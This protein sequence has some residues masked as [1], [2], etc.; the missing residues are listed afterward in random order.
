MVQYVVRMIKAALNMIDKESALMKLAL[1]YRL[2][3]LLR[4]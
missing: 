1:I 4:K 3:V 2:L